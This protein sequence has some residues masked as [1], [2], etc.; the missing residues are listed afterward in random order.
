MFRNLQGSDGALTI[1]L[2]ATTLV[3]VWC[4]LDFSNAKTSYQDAQ[5]QVSEAH[6]L[7]SMIRDLRTKQSV[8]RTTDAESPLS[9]KSVTSLVQSVGISESQLLNL[10]RMQ[11]LIPDTDYRREDLAMSLRGIGMPELC[12]L[13][14]AVESANLGVTATAITLSWSNLNSPTPK[15]TELWDVEL[16]LTHLVYH[17][18]R[19]QQSK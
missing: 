15:A 16:V 9:N 13:V 17:A 4:A 6:Q 3:L 12:Q 8:A 7:A 18:K 1:T 5:S 2:L 10:N 14:T 11:A 19:L